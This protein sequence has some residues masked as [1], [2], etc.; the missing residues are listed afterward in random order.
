M[1][2]VVRNDDGTYSAKEVDESSL[3][4]KLTKGQ[5][6]DNKND[7]GTCEALCCPWQRSGRD[8]RQ[9]DVRN[10]ADVPPLADLRRLVFLGGKYYPPRKY[11]RTTVVA[12]PLK[13]RLSRL[14]QWYRLYCTASR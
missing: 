12:A 1:K 2:L 9:S 8:T 3:K 14:P 7:P 11:Q 4:R 5:M 6:E 13:I 10:A